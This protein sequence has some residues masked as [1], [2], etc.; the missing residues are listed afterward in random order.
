M[1]IKTLK[2]FVA[3]AEHGSILKAANALHISQPPLTKQM[4][5]LEKELG[6]T[7]FLRSAKGVQLTEK[8]AF[9]Y[10]K[11]T[12]LISYSDS[13]LE[14][15]NQT[16]ED[17]INVGVITS[18]LQYALPLICQFG[19]ERNVNYFISE[20][21]SIEHIQMLESGVL[22]VAMVRV[23]FEISKD[24]RTFKLVDDCLYAIGD[25]SFFEKLDRGSATPD[26]QTISFQELAHV[27]LI[28]NHRWHTFLK[29]YMADQK[30]RFQYICE[31]NRTSAM[32]AMY[33]MGIALLPGS[34]AESNVPAGMLV[35][36]KIREDNMNCSLYLI[37]NEGRSN[38]P[39]TY[40]FI[41]YTLGKL[42]ENGNLK[43]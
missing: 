7:L 35:R 38:G 39:A 19:K 20:K 2:H 3:V 14:E 32:L 34:V 10:K 37:Y 18:S 24:I 33:G 22:D 29:R 1:D 43:L 31:D 23:P 40:D 4:Q 8:G 30:F 28:A 6:V 12:S 42:D 13:I 9:L 36:K 5:A 27:P 25:S 21:E 26:D 41:N 16:A 17:T 15:L 11:A